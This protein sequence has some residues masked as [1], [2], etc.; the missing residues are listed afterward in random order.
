MSE[1]WSEYYT[2]EQISKVQI[3]EL[4]CLQK[5]DEVCK[6]LGV[7]Y[8]VYGGTLIGAIRHNG[9]I[10]WDDDIDIAMNRKDYEIFIRDAQKFLGEEFYLQS[11]NKD[12][13]TP[14]L[15]S[16]LRL[17]G[18][19]LIEFEHHKLRIEKGIYIDIYPIDNISDN[20]EEYFKDHKRFQKI[21]K[22]YVLRQCCYIS[23]NSRK[24]SKKIKQVIKFCLSSLLKL[25]PQSLFLKKINKIC[26]KYNNQDTERVGNYFYNKPCNY[27]KSGFSFFQV[28]F[29][30]LI[31]NVPSCY[32]EHLKLR[33][34]DY[35]KLPPE[36]KRIGHKPFLID[37]GDFFV[38]K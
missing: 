33:Y 5:I 7:D 4:Y 25:I 8:F 1:L 32:D 12:K 17:K 16:K 36:E 24:M 30:N 20:D 34:D 21:A 10:P 29:E 13:K 15:Y 28:K 37:F 6:K 31:V 19:K 22:I 38:E 18:T 3:I 23:S 2:P 35:L 14:Y 11:P 9:F 27:F 26:T